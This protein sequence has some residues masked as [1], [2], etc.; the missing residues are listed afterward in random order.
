M[1]V[2]VLF[3]G[4][5]DS[6]FSAFIAKKKGFEICCLISLFSENKESYMFHTPNISLTKFQA[7]SM[8]LPL[9]IKK[10]KGNKEE[11]LSDLY[12]IL[13]NVK[14]KYSLDAIISGAVYSVYQFSRIK[15]ICDDLDLKLFNPLWQMKEEKLLKGLIKNNFEVILVGVFAYP[16]DKSFLGIKID[17]IFVKKFK[18]LN[19]KYG[20]SIIGEGGEFES[21]VLN[22]PL[23]N[24]KLVVE[25]FQDF[26]DSENSCVRKIKLSKN[27]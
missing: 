7:K 25:S 15:K 24:Q 17:E 18:E 1:K 16:L 4:G 23:F 5:K 14:R 10:T 11:E 9:V 22:C 21:F 26:C 27:I 12:N 13:R 8:N 6:V 20:V 19:K 3:S 2:G